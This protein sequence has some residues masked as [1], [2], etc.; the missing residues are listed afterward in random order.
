MLIQAL[1]NTAAAHDRY[2][3]CNSG[4]LTIKAEDGAMAENIVKNI[5][6]CRVKFYIWADKI[7]WPAIMGTVKKKLLNYCPAKLAVLTHQIL[8]FLTC[9]YSY[10]CSVPLHE[11][12][13]QPCSIWQPDDLKDWY[14]C[15]GIAN[16][17][18]DVFYASMI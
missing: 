2:E 10:T 7:Q 18:G 14:L 15:G 4:M 16:L 11:C 6:D 8:L 9:S 3:V 13:D 1:V 12:N 17:S 5:K